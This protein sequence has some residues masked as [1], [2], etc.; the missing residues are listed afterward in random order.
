MV[1]FFGFSISTMPESDPAKKI[2]QKSVVKNDFRL[3]GA[4]FYKNVPKPL[5]FIKISLTDSPQYPQNGP[6]GP[7][8]QKI[9]KKHFV[10]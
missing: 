7:L 1:Q 3:F 10:W 4:I 6:W 8:D 5:F 9:F 2:I